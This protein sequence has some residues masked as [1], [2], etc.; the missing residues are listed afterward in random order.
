MGKATSPGG[1]TDIGQESK[2]FQAGFEVMKLKWKLKWDDERTR[3]AADF[4]PAG[5]GAR[6]MRGFTLVQMLFVVAIVAIMGAIAVPSFVNNSRPDK[7]R[8]DARS[9]ASLIT[10]AK[11]RAS[12]NF[13]HVELYCTLTPTSGPANCQLKAMGFG[14]TSFVPEPPTNPQTVYLSSGVS[15]GIPATITTPVQN[16]TTGAYQ[17]DQAENTPSTTANPVIV[18]N[19]RG[20]PVDA[21]TGQN[22]TSDYALYLADTAGRYYAVTVNQTGHPALYQWDSAHLAFIL[23]PEYGTGT[24]GT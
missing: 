23:L 2:N 21:A 9:L 12:T 13:A 8:N 18:F 5:T 22:F 19:S 3:A 1:Y 11:M 14:A 6:R 17:G 4:E 24:S 7:I 20:L 16:Q 15:F 10:M